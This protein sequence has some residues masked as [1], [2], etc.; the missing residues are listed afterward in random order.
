MANQKL[1][2]RTAALIRK[3]QRLSRW[4]LAL[5]PDLRWNLEI[6]GI[7][8][9]EVRMRSN[10]SMILRN[11]AIYESFN[12]QSMQLLL[13]PGDIAYDVGANIGLFTRWMVQGCEASQ[14]VAFEPMTQNVVA[15]K[16]NVE[17]GRI[18]NKV[19]IIPCALSDVD[20]SDLLQIDD[21]MTAS[22]VLN[23]VS[24]GL[25]S[26]G[27]RSLGLPPRTEKVETRRLDTLLSS[28]ELAHVPPAVIKID[29]EGAEVA[30]L[31]GAN[32]VLCS[33]HP[34]LIVELHGA[35]QAKQILRMLFGYGY[36]VAGK[37][38]RR[39]D[40]SGFALLTSEHI[41]A[42]TG[43]YDV[44]HLVATRSRDEVLHVVDMLRR[45]DRVL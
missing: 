20:G 22:A 21:V 43:H 42:I 25:A 40:L 3:H 19:T 30:V 16:R 23:S 6:L 13:E 26:E 5:L 15:L 11:P 36:W 29:V 33:E 32:H 14:V 28:G 17:L 27:R 39:F 8:P 12:L 9:F 10:R 45:S 24:G 37:V 7:G 41:E 1:V 31:R 18:E 4:T 34:K 35:E 2:N 44:H 38:D